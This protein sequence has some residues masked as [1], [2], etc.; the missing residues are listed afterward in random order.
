[1]KNL[2]QRAMITAVLLLGVLLNIS[3]C[4]KT[5]TVEFDQKQ[6]SFSTNIIQ[7][8]PLTVKTNTIHSC[9]SL[10]SGSYGGTGYFAYEVD[11]LDLS[12]TPVGTIVKVTCDQ[13][14]VPNR[15]SIYEGSN[16]LVTTGWIGVADYPGPWGN[17]ISIPATTMLSFRKG[18]G[19]SYRLLIE[20]APQNGYTDTWNVAI[21]C[22]SQT[23][24]PPCAC[25]TYISDNHTGSGFYIYTDKIID[26]ACAPYGGKY[27]LAIQLYCDP[28]DV[29]NRFTVYDSNGQLVATSGWLGSAD[30]SGPWGMSLSKPAQSISFSRQG[31]SSFYYLRVETSTQPGYSDTWGVTVSCPPESGQQW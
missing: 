27:G 1:M 19:T 20:T 4:K 2:F 28:V 3:S 24:E 21:S 17:S 18:A 5:N 29:P 16:L 6:N 22:A 12:T 13:V 9:G 26:L 7:T 8:P 30:Y 23:T 15:F 25:G 31:I 14:E 10:Y 11:T